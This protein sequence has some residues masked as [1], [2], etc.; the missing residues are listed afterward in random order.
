MMPLGSPHLHLKSVDSTNDR[1]RALAISGAP[2]GTLV[3]ADH[4]SQGRGR[5][6]RDWIAP[7]GSSVLISLLLRD[8]PPL[9]PLIAAVAVAEIC[10]PAAR[11]KWPNDILLASDGRPEAKVAGI[12]CEARPQEAWA[13]VGV[14]LNAALD[15]SQLP[16]ELQA[17]SATLGLR[18]EQ[19]AALIDQLIESLQ[20]K[21]ALSSDEIVA[22]WN[23]RDALLGERIGWVTG[24]SQKSGTAAG[25]GHG[26]SLLVRLED[27]SEL[28]LNAGEVHLAATD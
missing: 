20:A 4:Q 14:G 3:S 9:L 8:P 21:L 22:F 28:E 13:V 23:E 19:R 6:G 18:S 24:G 25:I 2:H 12:L 17:R 11:I 26:G 1:A 16:S 5:Q 10:G 15:L 27:G 7:P